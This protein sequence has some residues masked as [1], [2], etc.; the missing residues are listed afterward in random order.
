MLGVF[1]STQDERHVRRRRASL[2][3]WFSPRPPRCPYRAPRQWLELD[4]ARASAYSPRPARPAR[5]RAS[6]GASRLARDTLA[7]PGTS[8]RPRR[9][10]TC[11]AVA[12]SAHASALLGGLL[13]I[14]PILTVEERR[15]DDVCQGAH[16][17]PGAVRD[18]RQVHRGY[19]GVRA[20]PGD[21][22]LHRRARLGRGVRTRADRADGRSPRSRSSR[23]A[24]SSACTWARRS[25]IV[26]ETERAWA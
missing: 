8:S 19:R 18:R 13:Q 15:D 4:G 23:S 20:A 5:A 6:S 24:R 1:V 3:T 7:A 10:S 21:R 16:A 17:Q 22:A 9:W 12:V 14:R 11:A 26:Y 2:P 25:A